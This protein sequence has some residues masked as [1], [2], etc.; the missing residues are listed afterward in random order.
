MKQYQVLLKNIDG[1]EKI[2]VISANNENDARYEGK[3]REGVYEAVVLRL[4]KKDSKYY[5]NE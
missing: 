5:I 2:I 4:N 1:T 3:K